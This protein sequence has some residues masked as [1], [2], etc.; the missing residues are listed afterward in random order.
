MFIKVVFA[1]ILPPVAVLL[2]RGCNLDF[3]LN[4]IL[5]CIAWFP[6]II[7]ALFVICRKKGEQQHIHHIHTT[8]EIIVTTEPQMMANASQAV[9]YTAVPP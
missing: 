5:T 6:G 7:H 9:V 1:V 4:L 3:V 8:R 2:D